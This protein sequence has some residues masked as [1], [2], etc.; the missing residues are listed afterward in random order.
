MDRSTRS[1]CLILFCLFN[2][3]IAQGQISS[4]ALVLTADSLVDG[5][6]LDDRLWKYHPGDNLQWANPEFDDSSW[7]IGDTWLN[8][9]DL[10]RSGW[11]GI[12]WFR[13]HIAVDSTLHNRLLA[14][15]VRHWGASE[16]YIDGKLVAQFGK[17]GSSLD[18]EEGY[19]TINPEFVAPPRHIGFHQAHHVI[20][21]RFSNF[22]PAEG[23][24]RQE[25][26]YGFAI[27]LSDLD[28][29]IAESVSQR[30][31]NANIQMA[32][33][34]VPV[35][36]AMLHML[37]FLFYQRARENLYYALFT[38]LLG[39]VFFTGLQT[40]F[41]MVTDL[42]QIIFYLKLS[43]A[44][45]SF[46]LLAGLRFLYSLFYERLPR[47]FWAFLGV[48]LAMILLDWSQPFSAHMLPDIMEGLMLVEMCRVA[49]VAI[50]QRKDGA[51]IIGSGMIFFAMVMLW[52]VF[53]L[54]FARMG[55]WPELPMTFAI[56]MAAVGILGLLLSMSIFLARS[57]A[58]TR[59]ALQE[60]TDALRKLNLE[61]EDRVKQRT[62][63]LTEA[64]NLLENN[65]VQ[66]SESYEQLDQAHTQLQETQ[67]QLV[68][69]EKMAALG[70]LVAGI[71]HEINNPVGAVSS[72]ADVS[73]RAIQKINEALE[74]NEDTDGIQNNRQF[75]RAL[76]VL[77]NNNRATVMASDRI[78]KL[79][80][81][82][83][84]FARLD[85]AE[86]QKSNIHEGIDNTLTLVEFELQD[87]ITVSKQYGDIPEIYCYPNQLNQMFMNLF[88]NAARAIEGQ[89]DIQITTTAD[90]THVR[91][92]VADTG[93]GIA[94]ENLSKIFE[95]GFTT[96][97]SGVG[98]GLGLSI[99]YNII[100]KHG[101]S[102]DVESEVGKGTTFSVSLP[103]EPS[104]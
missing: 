96:K 70:Q 101:G 99:S 67:I 31:E 80:Q 59:N 77:T 54:I 13:L 11:T 40:E 98:M 28:S 43:D 12:G 30:R 14:L 9:N 51:W 94:P 76:K 32:F 63:E 64:N 81:G 53:H 89:G 61:L 87:R 85:E 62:V 27:V 41:S 44:M 37:L 21:V 102:I 19:W 8:S 22:F 69:S 29:T 82:L 72:A 90:R 47:Q 5:I 39:A 4:P 91:I 75:L 7:E 46:M 34:I 42:Q 68:Q 10:P 58:R 49:V 100:Q 45:F 1:L 24:N 66:L 93:I 60:Q 52:A 23:L 6:R 78:T 15:N 83:K 25:L 103:I 79:V 86:F 2:L 84:N 33:G 73:N 48:G 50:L 56:A 36:F 95:P 17:V 20:A 65:N 16:I 55:I 3:T 74:A 18:D 26:S 71:A 38:S 104:G 97:G 35:V 88:A 57:F 92:Q